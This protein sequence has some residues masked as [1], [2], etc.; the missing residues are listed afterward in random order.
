MNLSKFLH[1]NSLLLISLFLLTLSFGVSRKVEKPFVF[2]SKQEGSINF[3]DKLLKRFNLGLKRLLSSS[4]WISTILESDIDHYKNKDLNSWMFLRFKSISELEPLFY[5]NYAFGGPYLSIIKDDLEGASSIYNTGL[6]YYPQDYKLL[7]D[8]GFHFYF[9]VGDLI[10]S[11]EIYSSLKNHPKTS[12][13]IHSTLARLE[14]NKGNLPT[15]FELLLS[16]YNEQP[17]KESFF[18]K[19]LRQNLYAI[20]AEIDTTC[21]NTIPRVEICSVRDL[22]NEN[23]F[24][25]E[26]KYLARK[27]W[28]PF[29]VKGKRK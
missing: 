5:E 18:A 20:K 7:R 27:V 28:V 2:I 14:S 26:G 22:D 23:Y 24:I 4:L 16:K 6:S 1:R 15:A 3:N 12:I 13:Q 19:K 21:L 25:H 17:D 10:R 9:E 29:R 11:Y 8:A